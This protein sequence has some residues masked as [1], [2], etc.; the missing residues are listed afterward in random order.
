MKTCNSCNTDNVD[1]AKYCKECGVALTQASG[2][3]SDREILIQVR[4]L[5]NKS[6]KQSQEYHTEYQQNVKRVWQFDRNRNLIMLA[7]ITVI[8]GLVAIVIILA[9]HSS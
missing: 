1:D 6:V 7:A 4:D 9:A 3:S 2:E 5:L 8:F